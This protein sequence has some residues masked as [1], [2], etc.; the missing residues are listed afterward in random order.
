VARLDH[1]IL[2]VDDLD[3]AASTMSDRYG[4]VA[5]TGGV[6]PDGVANRVI[7][8]DPPRY[9]ELIAIVDREAAERLMPSDELLSFTSRKGWLGWA[10]GGIDLDEVSMRTGVEPV[11]GSLQDA[12]GVTISSWRYVAPSDDAGGALPFFVDYDQ[13]AEERRTLWTERAATAAHPAGSASLAWVDIAIDEPRLRGWIGDLELPIRLAR[14]TPRIRSVCVRTADGN[15][16]I[17]GD[18]IAS[19]R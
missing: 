17:D 15:V 14:G 5:L 9:L 2:H 8:L 1:V 7:P 19:G 6:F 4:L 16:I 11:A 12:D 13:T 18:A 10:I 3:A